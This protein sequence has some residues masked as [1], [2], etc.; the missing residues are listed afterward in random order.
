MDS[1]EDLTVLTKEQI[2]TAFEAVLE[3]P[4]RQT[5]V[6]FMVT[7]GCTV[8]DLA[9]YIWDHWLGEPES[10]SVEDIE[11]IIKNSLNL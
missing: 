5:D 1:P 2:E 6:Q 4:P 9:E 3:I 11:E 8:N 10:P 7:A